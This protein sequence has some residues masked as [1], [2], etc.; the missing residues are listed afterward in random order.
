[1]IATFDGQIAWEDADICHGVQQAMPFLRQKAR[2]LSF[3]RILSNTLS[4]VGMGDTHLHGEEALPC[5]E[6]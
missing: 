3:K 4:K 2:R 5:E 6:E 1:M